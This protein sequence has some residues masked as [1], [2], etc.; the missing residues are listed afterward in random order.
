MIIK[1]DGVYTI[2]NDSAGVRCVIT[3]LFSK[4]VNLERNKWLSAHAPF[5]IR[6]L[7]RSEFQFFLNV[8]CVFFIICTILRN[9]F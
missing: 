7:A 8:S 4:I 9:D 3:S 6:S 1:C 2:C 5:L